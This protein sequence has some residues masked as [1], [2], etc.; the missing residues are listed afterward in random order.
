M[1]QVML[2]KVMLLQVVMM[3][4]MSAQIELALAVV[5][6]PRHA[7]IDPGVQEPALAL[8]WVPNPR[9]LRRSTSSSSPWFSP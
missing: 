4:M 5:E 1:L 9:P 2:S 6:A 7:G 3:M 8:T